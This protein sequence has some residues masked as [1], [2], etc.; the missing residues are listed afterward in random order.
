MNDDEAFVDPLDNYEPKTYA[1]PLEKAI[2]EETVSEIQHQPHAS[3][4]PEA[5]VA[6]AVNKLATE[7]VACLLVEDGGRLVGVFTDREVLNKVA[8]EP[9][10][11]DKPVREL[12]TADPVY[13]YEDDAAAAALCV[14]AVSGYRHVPIVNSDEQVKGIISPKRVTEFLSKHLAK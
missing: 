6:E 10:S 13:V 8:L 1:D 5:S 11:L 14:M 7:H 9:A 3:I 2:A 12:M 4:G